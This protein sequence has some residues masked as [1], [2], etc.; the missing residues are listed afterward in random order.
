MIANAD[1]QAA[2]YVFPYHHLP[3]LDEGGHPH[4]GRAMRGGL[5]YLSYLLTVVELVERLAPGRLLDVGCGDGRLLLELSGSVPV[6]VGVDLDERAIAHAVG[7]APSAD[8]R[9]E[10][11]EQ[12]VET[13]DVVTC[14]ETLEHVPDGLEDAFLASVAARVS[15]GGHLVLTV[16]STARPVHEKHHRHYS[17]DD[18]GH[19]IGNLPGRW[20]LEQLQEIVPCHR[21]LEVGLRLVVNRHWTLDV[22]S[23]N[24]G[25]LR[26]QRRP[27]RV[28]RRGFHVLAVVRR[29]S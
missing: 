22:P 25:V 7:F 9:C 15:P 13:F 18:V 2:E 3:H 1:R 6:A 20:D 17:V 29:G 14:V 4:V 26:L 21:W 11:V 23:I 16:P 10:A 28:S 24:R 8:F 19:R 12:I 27:V 5:E